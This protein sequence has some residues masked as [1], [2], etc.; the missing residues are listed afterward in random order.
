MCYQD[1][2][3]QEILK[4]LDLH[5]DDFVYDDIFSGSD[6][7]DLAKNLK[8]TS[9]DTTVSFSFDGAQL[10]QSKKSDTW[11]GVWIVNDYNPDSCYKKI[12]VLPAF[13]AQDPTNPKTLIHIH[14]E[15][16]ITFQP[17]STKTMRKGFMCG[18]GS[19]NKQSTHM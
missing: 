15:A 5:P 4:E 19:R 6:F 12:R 8:L 16:F 11:I 1:A 10:Y 13:I 2:K 18:M 3:T 14:F 7:L 17:Y 9:D